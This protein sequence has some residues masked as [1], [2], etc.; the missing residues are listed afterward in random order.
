MRAKREQSSAHGRGSLFSQ[1][2]SYK[3]E[4]CENFEYCKSGGR[5]KEP[6]RTHR[7]PYY[8]SDFKKLKRM[9]DFVKQNADVNTILARRN[10]NLEKSI[11]TSEIRSPFR[12]KDRS[13]IT[14]PKAPDASL[15]TSKR[16]FILDLLCKGGQVLAAKKPEICLLYT[17]DAADE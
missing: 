2:T 12:S 11:E 13:R 7:S 3:K 8:S 15:Y 1:C 6:K 10:I 17:S 9:H 14:S 4:T 5:G 16:S